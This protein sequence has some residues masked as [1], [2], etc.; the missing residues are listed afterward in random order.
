MRVFSVRASA[1]ISRREVG[2]NI[3]R[4][5]GLEFGAESRLVSDGEYEGAV[6]VTEEQLDAIVADEHLRKSAV[7]VAVEYPPEP[8]PPDDEGEGDEGEEVE[9]AAPETAAPNSR[10]GRKAKR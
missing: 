9:P 6:V 4:R 8:S 7:A 3:R 10:R 1:E 2:R 5:A